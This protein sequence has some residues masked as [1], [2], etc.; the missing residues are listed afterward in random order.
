MKKKRNYKIIGSL[1]VV[2]FF[3]GNV[4]GGYAI[5]DQLFRS[6]QNNIIQIG[7]G[8]T[9]TLN[10]VS[11]NY[12]EDNLLIADNMPLRTDDDINTSFQR[13]YE[14]ELLV[15]GTNELITPY[16]ENGSG[17]MWYAEIKVV[18][19]LVL[20]NGTNV[21]NDA[22]GALQFRID[23]TQGQTTINNDEYTVASFQ[24]NTLVQSVLIINNGTYIPTQFTI[25]ISIINLY[26]DLQSSALHDSSITF[27]LQLEI[28]E[29]PEAMQ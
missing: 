25:L 5:W 6:V 29:N 18:N 4:V 23:F 1:G 16:I 27:D 19:V 22:A 28:T 15:K 20:K 2:L 12:D 10:Q 3:L 9:A 26:T 14:I 8:T 21:T 7:I 24:N 13:T 11:L 17:E